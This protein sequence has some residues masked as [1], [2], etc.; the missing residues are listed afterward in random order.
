MGKF[1]YKIIRFLLMLPINIIKYFC[2]GF[3]F[4]CSVLIEIMLYTIY[5]TS[6]LV[7]KSVKYFVL[8]F[9]LPILIFNSIKRTVNKKR[10]ARENAI[11]MIPTEEP[12]NLIQPIVLDEASDEE[13][14]LDVVN[15]ADLSAAENPIEE[16]FSVVESTE[17][18]LNIDE[19]L[20]NENIVPE[21]D[22]LETI[23]EPIN[24]EKP[25][26]VKLPKKKINV[27]K[28]LFLPFEIISYPVYKLFKYICLG[29]AFV[30]NMLFKL[31]KYFVFGFAFIWVLIYR[32][33]KAILS[34]VVYASLGVW[35]IIKYIGHAFVQTGVGAYT[36][37]KYGL[38]GF[39][40]TCKIIYSGFK[41]MLSGFV[42]TSFIVYSGFKYILIG[43]KISLIGIYRG[44]IYLSYFVY[45]I[46][47]YLLYSLSLP[48]LIINII[49]TANKDKIARHRI[50]KEQKKIRLQEEKIQRKLAAQQKQEEKLREKINK[51]NQNEYVNENVKIEK[52]TFKEQFDELLNK[53]FNFPAVLS[54]KIKEAIHNSVFM[55]NKRNRMDINRQALLINFE[56]EDAEKSDVKLIY[57]Y[58]AK[59][60]EG[61]MITGYM[62]AFSKVEIHSFLLSEG[63]EVYNIKTNKWIQM[64]HQNVADSK[65]K[66]KTKDLIFFLTQLST[67]I[68]AGIPLVD[69]LKIL[70]RQY[71]KN[72]RYERLFKTIIYDL[73]MGDNFSTALSKQGDA[74]PRILINM[75]KASEMTGE[76][77]E[78]LD[79]MAEY[80]TEM[81][82]TRKQMITALMYPMIILVISIAV[83]VFILLFVIPKFVDIYQSMDASKVPAF[84]LAVLAVSNFLKSYAIYLLIGIVVLIVLLIYLYKNVKVFRTLCQ[85]LFMHMPVI[86]NV[87]IYNEVTNFTKTFASLL[88]HNVYITDSMEILTRVTNNEIYKMLILDT[89][90]N[91]AKGEKIS[92]SF[93]DHWAFPIPAYEMLVTGE[94]TGQLPEMMAKVSDYYQE[95]H[96]NTVTR[97]KTFVEPILIIFLTVVVGII[98]LA[99]IIPMFGMYQSVQDYS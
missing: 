11:I 37:L 29:I 68:K 23:P 73:S 26:K 7:Y 63:Y 41:Y 79:D 80:F 4:I 78:V 70:Q 6:F 46:F 91:L 92:T 16:H 95:L 40:K 50:L 1:V 12:N 5:F 72:K 30:V 81:D 96:K 38:S 15:E 51:K 47:K 34:G 9:S 2:L 59:T 88:S 17:N 13:I 10:E 87:I 14:L 55:K 84:T 74:F 53:I 85:W 60:P 8:S 86:K 71:S 35:T 31:V 82:K 42:F 36:A 33:F 66:M 94:Q 49:L 43:C 24:I 32:I 54:K 93:K 57:Q 56:G 45:K 77:P 28:Y 20:A 99:I 48:V 65:A 3:Y 75:V 18:I 61:K 83:V 44:F 21:V 67:Y 64:L 19:I 52:K 62:E 98:V 39:V 58:T 90:T 76:L 89:I 22:V 25:K 69:S 97:I 27:L